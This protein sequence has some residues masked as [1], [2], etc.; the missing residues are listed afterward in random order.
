MLKI[1]NK[2]MD[3]VTH[4]LMEGLGPLNPISMMAHSG[5]LCDGSQIS[6]LGGMYGFIT[7]SSGRI[8]D[9]PVKANYCEGLTVQEYFFSTLGARKNLVDAS[10]KNKSPGNLTCRLVDAAHDVIIC[11]EDCE[12]RQGISLSEYLERDYNLEE[13]I[14]RVIGRFTF[15]PVYHPDTGEVIV[16]R[17]QIIDED[18]AKEIL[19]LG[20]TG[21]RFRS[22]LTCRSRYGI[23]VKCYGRNLATGEIVD[24]GEAVGII[25]AQSIGEPGTQLTMSMFHTGGVAGNDITQGL[26]RVEELFEARKPK[27]PLLISEVSGTIE[28]QETRCKREL[29]VISAHGDRAYPIPYGAMLKVKDGQK[30]SAGDGLTEGPINPH[31]LLKVKGVR[32]VQ[33]YLLQEVQRVYR[34][35]GVNINDKHI[36]VIIR[37]MLKKVKVEDPGD[38]ELLP[39]VIIDSHLFDGINKGVKDKDGRPAQA[40]PLFLG[41]TKAS[42][43]TGSFLSAASLRGTAWT[44]TKAAFRGKHDLL[45]G[46]K[47][48]VIIGRTIPAGTGRT[49]YRNIKVNVAGDGVSLN[50]VREKNNEA[51]KNSA[52]L[53]ASVL[54]EP[55]IKINKP[56]TYEIWNGSIES[57]FRTW[58]LS[59]GYAVS[60]SGVYCNLISSVFKQ[61]KPLADAAISG[62]NEP[63]K[64]IRKFIG[65]L[66]RDKNFG[67]SFNCGQILSSLK[68]LK[69]Y[70]IDSRSANMGRGQQKEN[71]NFR[72]DS[73]VSPRI[74]GINPVE[75][76]TFNGS[77]KSVVEPIL[78]KYFPS[79]IRPSS[80]IDIKKLGYHIR[81]IKGDDCL[82]RDVDIPLLLNSIGI[83]HG[84]KI[85]AVT[86]NSRRDLAVLL[87]HLFAEKNRLFF[88]K[89]LYS[90]HDEFMQKIGIFFP[91]LLRTVLIETLP[92]LCYLKNS[93]STNGKATVRSEMLRCYETEVYLSY[94][95]FKSKLPYVPLDKIKQ[96]LAQDRDY[97]RVE[98]GVY[99]HA[100]RL[101]F[102]LNELRT[103]RKSIEDGILK[104]GYVSL[105]SL[106]VPVNLELN[107]DLSETAVKNGLFQVHLAEHYEKRGSVIT[108]KG[109][110]LSPVDLL[111]NYCLAHD[112]LT[113]DQLLGFEKEI[114]G[115]THSQ[116]L[117]VAYDTMVRV[118]R[119]TFVSEGA[120][121]FDIKAT[122]KALSLFL[123]KDVI[124]LQAVTSFISFPHVEGYPWNWYL[125]ESY[126]KRFSNL[127]KYQCLSVNSL[128]VGAIYRKSAGF[129]EYI[130]V[131]ASAMASSDIELNE[132]VVG[133]YLFE[134]RYVAKRTGAVR[135]VTEKAR[136]LRS[137]GS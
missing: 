90:V 86:Q 110:V 30:V 124:P 2:A 77:L 116:S 81:E 19:R 89:E 92:S 132:K 114:Y 51:Q 83:R 6:Q 104:R 135:E 96:V 64:A 118:D 47:E 54:G 102:D 123:T 55:K 71:R 42:L 38:T 7:N 48:N 62:N 134:N 11:E 111:S 109:K 15:E 88:Y 70:M 67:S 25:A 39:G 87:E 78:E 73:M 41:I 35:Q 69:N 43:A 34:M 85:F 1:W 8:A 137:K 68:A 115:R 108:P 63:I 22:A 50:A 32:G 44:L 9:L 74:G 12:A 93:F 31:E 119:Y 100:S 122:D 131:L 94:D 112:R 16:D 58:M 21:V 66:E 45:L 105:A 13:A 91:E 113:L 17:D 20:I 126:C 14:K 95:G 98:T 97:I 107:P 60:T 84:K 27:W 52:V 49:C 128:N 53:C 23:C 99:T 4:S 40:R 33:L 136:I 61:Y 10:L 76:T 106:D 29:R 5:A 121:N 117:L 101:I 120:V 37:Q 133:D 36:E 46:L 56:P 125:L 26:L 103:V 3:E 72:H 127:F 82:L 79:G 24:V 59:R 75:R 18:I 129:T 65:L 130:D 28:I 57:S 80:V